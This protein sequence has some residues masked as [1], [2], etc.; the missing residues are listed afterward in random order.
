MG[1]GKLKNKLGVTNLDADQRSRLFKDFRYTGGKVLREEDLNFNEMEDNKIQELI[2]LLNIKEQEGQLSLLERKRLDS[3]RRIQ[4]QRQKGPRYIYHAV[5]KEAEKTEETEE[6]K[7]EGEKGERKDSFR[8][9]SYIHA[10]SGPKRWF[11]LFW[12]RIKCIFAGVFP[13]FRIRIKK[14]FLNY[15]GDAVRHALQVNKQI[16]ASILYKDVE[17]SQEIKSNFW[18]NGFFYYYEIIFR[19]DNLLD[20]ELFDQIAEL[21][22]IGNQQIKEAH[23]SLTKFYK[24]LFILKQYISY[25]KDALSRSMG[26]EARLRMLKPA[27]VQGNMKTLARHI[28]MLF[29]RLYKKLNLLVDFFYLNRVKAGWKHNF[30]QFI[31]FVK[32]DHIGYLTRM[33][34]ER[35]EYERKRKQLA[36]IIQGKVENAKEIKAQNTKNN[37]DLSEGLTDAIRE[38]MNFIYEN[39][40]FY[41]ALEKGRAN[42]SDDYVYFHLRDKVFV[43]N[44]LVDFFDKEFSF[45]FLSNR[46]VYSVFFDGTGRKVDVKNSLRDLYYKLNLVYQRVREYLA[47]VRQL[48][49]MINTE[50]PSQVELSVEYKNITAQKLNMMRT[51]HQTAQKIFDQ[52][53]RILFYIMS[54]YRGPRSVIQNPE[55]D[56]RMGSKVAEVNIFKNR[57]IIE[58][59]HTANSFV[60]A[61][62]YLLN[63]GELD[64]VSL[65]VD[66]PYYLHLVNPAEIEQKIAIEEERKFEE[67]GEKAA[68]TGEKPK[69]PGMEQSAAADQSKSAEDV[70]APE[71][72]K[73]RDTLAEMDSH[74]VQPKKTQEEGWVE[75]IR[76]DIDL[77]KKV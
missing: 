51:I 16:L 17:L 33:W 57:S 15:I 29:Y 62:N 8:V 69:E 41:R 10:E 74:I 45:L 44:T 34:D 48:K 20:D 21:K 14:S 4:M 22:R 75:D 40:D 37:I 77:L 13:L 3:A 54:D 52:F 5:D 72:V 12:A 19:F 11:Q 26:M 67:E 7:K 71:T 47:A 6:Q 50:N 64:M 49:K 76:Q 2:N 32:E 63:E 35:D 25:L 30:L 60:S 31:G 38:G 66:D 68:D 28:E 36:E 27:I 39:L 73:K 46:V 18:R 61:F 53:E 65:N 9:P 42:P 58:V 70:P 55:E 23:L 1:L 24:K 43:I 56:V 59:F